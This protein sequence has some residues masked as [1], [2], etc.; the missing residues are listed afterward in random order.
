MP[1]AG[2]TADQLR[3]DGDL[4][5]NG[6]FSVTGALSLRGA[7]IGAN[8]DLSDATPGAAGGLAL[9]G[10]DG[11]IRSCPCGALPVRRCRSA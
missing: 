10:Y 3:T 1:A 7:N 5:F 8:L 6:G 9:D 4:S 11:S 2:V